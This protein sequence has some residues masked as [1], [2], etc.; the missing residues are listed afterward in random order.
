MVNIGAVSYVVGG[1]AFLILTILL[2]T[3]WRGRLQGALLVVSYVG[4]EHYLVLCGC[5]QRRYEQSP[6]DRFVESRSSS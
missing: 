1:L 4:H 2:I 3:S 6:P 5:L